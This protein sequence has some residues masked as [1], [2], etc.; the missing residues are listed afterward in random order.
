VVKQ[1]FQVSSG[2]GYQPEHVVSSYLY[3]DFDLSNSN[4]PA[5]QQSHILGLSTWN[6]HIHPSQEY[7]YQAVEEGQPGYQFRQMCWGLGSS[8]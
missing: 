5:D 2:Q 8:R 4:M 6:K 7:W 3:N 1:I